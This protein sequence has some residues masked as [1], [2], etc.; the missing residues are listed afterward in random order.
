MLFTHIIL[1]VSFLLTIR[2]LN[3]IEACMVNIQ[4]TTTNLG[5][6]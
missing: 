4:L 5:S 6:Q 2:L 3:F 1:D